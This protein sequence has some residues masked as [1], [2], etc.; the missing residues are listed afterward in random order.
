MCQAIKW[1]YTFNCLLIMKI[2]DQTEK[3]IVTIILQTTL[4]NE[5]IWHFKSN[6]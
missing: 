3:E 1:N 4:S 6:F 5:Y 2:I